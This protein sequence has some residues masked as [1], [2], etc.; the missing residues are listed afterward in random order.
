M[1]RHKRLRRRNSGDLR[2]L[3]FHM[4]VMISGRAF[5]GRF[6]GATDHRAVAGATPFPIESIHAI[7]D[8][9][10][11]RRVW[12][13][14]RLEHARCAWMQVHHCDSASGSRRHG[15]ELRSNLRVAEGFEALR[16]LGRPLGCAQVPMKQPLKSTHL[17]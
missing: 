13:G 8:P 1:E 12:S 16:H 10:L 3:L 2:A 15:L 11:K 5:A 14:A 9:R 17:G 6:P 7:I 4:R